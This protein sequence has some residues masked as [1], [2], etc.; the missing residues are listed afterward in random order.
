MN[1]A[2]AAR[3][4]RVEVW[5]D[6]VCPFCYLEEPVL[7]RTEE[8]FKDRVEVRWRAFELRPDPVP[9][10]DPQGVYLQDI[11]ARA[12]YPMAEARG[13]TLRLPPVQPRSRLALEAAEYARQ[14][15]RYA[16]M[17]HAIFRAFFE[18]GKDIGSR[19]VL[20]EIGAEAGLN[21]EELRVALEEGRFTSRVVE[22]EH[23]AQEIGISGVP[24]LVIYRLDDPAGTATV[25]DG[26]QPYEQVRAAIERIHLKRGEPS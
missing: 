16:E 10:L 2:A 11:W 1:P 21:R 13:M 20:L 24:A 26:A 9:T 18:D 3:A 8:E 15:G 14:Q 23:L 22:D 6:Y 19:E 4:V 17:H 12:V 7:K 25:L 5:S